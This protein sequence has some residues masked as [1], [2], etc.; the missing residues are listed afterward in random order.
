[1]FWSRATCDGHDRLPSLGRLPTAPFGSVW[2]SSCSVMRCG[3]VRC[4]PGRNEDHQVGGGSGMVIHQS[5]H[6]MMTTAVK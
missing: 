2:F 3:A 5:L 4:Q 6:A 1:M